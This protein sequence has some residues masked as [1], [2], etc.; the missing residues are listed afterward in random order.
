MSDGTQTPSPGGFNLPENY[1]PLHDPRV[2]NVTD[3]LHS[4]IAVLNKKVEEV[5]PAL[6]EWKK[7]QEDKK[8]QSQRFEELT[9]KNLELENWQ[10]Q[11]VKKVLVDTKLTHKLNEMALAGTQILPQFIAK[12]ELYQVS[13]VESQAFG[14]ALASILNRAYVDQVIAFKTINQPPKPIFPS[15][16]PGLSGNPSIMPIG[17]SGQPDYEAYKKV[18]GQ[19]TVIRQV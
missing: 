9:R 11:T 4:Q 16:T 15:Q 19:D 8:T 5:T 2:K 10:K 6:E 3:Q 18:F 7:A 17:S 12:E 13:D 1:N 14:D